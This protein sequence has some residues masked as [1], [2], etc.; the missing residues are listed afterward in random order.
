MNTMV[1][2]NANAENKTEEQNKASLVINVEVSNDDVANR[3][4]RGIMLSD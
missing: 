1:T 3:L 4:C 2:A